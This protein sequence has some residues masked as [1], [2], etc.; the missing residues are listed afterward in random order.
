MEEYKVIYGI[1]CGVSHGY[2]IKYPDYEERTEKILAE[3][4][5]SALRN[6]IMQAEKF[7]DDYLSNPDTGLTTVRILNLVGP[8]GEVSFNIKDAI[9]KRSMLE[10]LL[11]S[12]SK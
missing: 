9:V 12:I 1:N 11:A 4:D 3:D 2:G 8:N 6:T 10:H 7:A 5:D